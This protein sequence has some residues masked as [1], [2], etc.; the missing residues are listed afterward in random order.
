LAAAAEDLS[1][2]ATLQAADALRSL[3]AE[4]ARNLAEEIRR[5]PMVDVP[6]SLHEAREA[7]R[8]AGEGAARAAEMAGNGEW[9][10]ASRAHADAARDLS[11]A[12]DLLDRA[13]EDLARMAGEAESRPAD[14]S[15]ADVPA[16]ALAR[17]FGE[18]S[19]A[20]SAS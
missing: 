2:G 14:D 16:D 20:A 10:Q 7:S 3:Q 4:A 5:L 1:R 15:R 9:E 17:A 8:K 12:A 11:Q 6:G 18:A 13:V 19:K